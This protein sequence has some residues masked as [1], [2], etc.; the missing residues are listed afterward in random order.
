M[1][2]ESDDIPYLI[3]SYTNRTSIEPESLDF[4]KS[5]KHTSY[6]LSNQSSYNSNTS[7]SVAFP[8][9]LLTDAIRQEITEDAESYDGRPSFV[10]ETPFKEIE[11]AFSLMGSALQQ[12]ES[13]YTIVQETAK[14][15]ESS[16]A[17][18]ESK[19]KQSQNLLA[20]LYRE[21]QNLKTAP[22]IQT[23]QQTIEVLTQQ[24]ETLEMKQKTLETQTNLQN[25]DLSKQ[26][27]MFE[28]MLLLLR[29][30][31]NMEAILAPIT[32]TVKIQKELVESL[33]IEI[34]Q[35]NQNKVKT[36][37]LYTIA[38]KDL[39]TIQKQVI[40]SKQLLIDNA[41]NTIQNQSP[42]RNTASSAIS[43]TL[44]SPTIDGG[45]LEMTTSDRKGRAR[46]PS[47]NK[48]LEPAKKWAKDLKNN[49]GKVT[50]TTKN[51][52]AT[53]VMNRD[54]LAKNSSSESLNDKDTSTDQFKKTDYIEKPYHRF[55]PH[56]YLGPKRCDFCHTQIW[57]KE[58][59]CEE[60][61]AGI[62]GVEFELL[63]KGQP[64]MI[65]NI[66][67]K[68]VEAVELRGLEVEGIYRKSGPA[69]QISQ[70]IASFNAGE[71]R[72]LNDSDNHIEISAITS[73]LKQFLRELP[74]SLI[75][76]KIY[77]D[78][79]AAMRKEP[80]PER[81]LEMESLIKQCPKE[82]LSTLSYLIHHLHRYNH[83]TDFYR[84]QLNSVKNLMVAA[85]LGMVFGPNLLKSIVQ[86]AQNDIIDSN[87]KANIVEHLIVNVDRFF[88]L[89]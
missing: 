1:S 32:A 11:S 76:S 59:K 50:G 4:R 31:Q 7:S 55:L 38:A 41:I 58:L 37:E 77:K 81:E 88:P 17:E 19:H 60:N 65:P 2:S 51:T 26:M 87:I 24:V 23:Q 67:V 89:N 48:T 6:I 79:T 61:N 29:R 5:T 8:P 47:I 72:S 53:T 22:I 70:L 3:D 36:M 54:K 34:D 16:L 44:A 83:Q 84:V 73:V 82:N 45:K 43:V 78:I 49:I 25:L 18:E 66:I 52:H 68:C 12:L 80:S 33:K 57:G 63:A 85:N 46:S 39:V 56:N 13:R 64:N 15:L 42:T 9:H 86:T 71:D 14:K 27:E 28:Q 62:F 69:S 30:M 74:D 75:C 20:D 10:V 21:F 40:Q 35:L